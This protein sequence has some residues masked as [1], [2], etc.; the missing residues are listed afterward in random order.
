[1]FAKFAIR[2]ARA[3][4][5]MEIGG[6][7]ASSQLGGSVLPSR[8][9][10][11]QLFAPDRMTG[12]RRVDQSRCPPYRCLTHGDFPTPIASGALRTLEAALWMY[13]AQK[14]NWTIPHSVLSLLS[15]RALTY[16]H[17]PS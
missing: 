2:L 13:A 8:L 14:A 6:E 1:M 11:T 3:D 9:L 12:Y 16:L 4:S 5:G 10:L 17:R 15:Q 7:L